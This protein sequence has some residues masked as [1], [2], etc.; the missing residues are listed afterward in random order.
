[1]KRILFVLLIANAV[2]HGQT[3]DILSILNDTIANVPFVFEGRVD[4]VEVF[5]GDDQGNR[6]PKSAAHW[7]NG[8]AHFYD[9]QDNEAEGYTSATITVCR[10]Y[11]GTLPQNIVMVTKAEC[12]NNMYLVA[13]GKDTALQ[14]VNVPPSHG[15]PISL[16][17]PSASY[18][19]SKLFF[20][21]RFVDA[22]EERYVGARYR[23]NM[24]IVYEAPMHIQTLKEKPDGSAEAVQSYAVIY[25]YTFADQKELSE[26]LGKIKTLNPNPSC[27]CVPSTGTKKKEIV[28]ESLPD[29]SQNR[30]NYQKWFANLEERAKIIAQNTSQNLGKKMPN[31]DITLSMANERIVRI[32]TVNWFEFDVMVSANSPVYLDNAL[33]RIGYSNGVFGNSVILNNNIIATNGPNFNNSTYNTAQ[34]VMTDM[35]S[36][37]INLGIGATSSTPNRTQVNSTPQ[38]LVAIRMKIATCGS[39]VNLQFEDQASVSGFEWYTLAANSSSSL[40]FD[41]VNFGSSIIDPACVP[42]LTAFTAG[43]PAGIGSILTIDGNYFGTAKSTLGTVVF[44]NADKGN[45]YPVPSGSNWG[46]IQAYDIVSWTDDQIQIRLPSIIDS[47]F[48]FDIV[49]GIPTLSGLKQVTPGTGK[50]KIRNSTGSSIESLAQITIPYAVTQ[51]TQVTSSG[52]IKFHPTLS[53]NT[54]INGY[55]VQLHTNVATALTNDAKKTVWKAMREWTCATGITWQLG[56]DTTITPQSDKWCTIYMDPSHSSLMETYNSVWSCND[57]GNVILYLRGFDIAIKTNPSSGTWEIDTINN[58]AAAEYDFFS[59]ISHELGH[60]HQVSH[61]NDSIVDLMWWE[62]K[63]GFIAYGARKLIKPSGNART[64]GEWVTDN[65]VATV[66]CTGTHILTNS[67]NCEEFLSINGQYHNIRNVIYPNPS[68]GKFYIGIGLGERLL[69]VYD[70]MGRFVLEQ[71]VRDGDSFEIPE[72]GLFIVTTET[73][74]TRTATKVLVQ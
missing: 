3:R 73:E 71:R 11:K 52:Y 42:K 55:R 63:P 20:V 12:I 56:T 21:D 24:N 41:N 68:T 65:N 33:L 50:F 14:F 47:G 1:M 44:K 38:I 48:V 22:K 5:P 67:F 7:E 10:S 16:M 19:I 60:A 34:S 23:S 51:Y 15:L 17:L 2:G 74:S 54:S 49:G 29:Y 45:R 31:V 6:L 27:N 30:A 69:K 18:P 59:A 61:I 70:V 58:I 25:P 26:F 4:A 62:G 36:S 9:K 39:A 35:T 53:G 72:K 13:N 46:G 28:E 40:I 66:S 57:G 37:Q 8:L 64:A 43:V 32:G